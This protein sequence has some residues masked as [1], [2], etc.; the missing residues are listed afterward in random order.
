LGIRAT[1][2]VSG[3]LLVTCV[4]A[5]A[6]TPQQ[7]A[8]QRIDLA[9]SLAAGMLRAVNRDVT[10][11]QGSQ[12]G[13]HMSD[14]SDPGIVW[15]Q[16]SD[17]TQGTI[18]VDVRGRDQFQRS[19]IGIAFHG[20]DDRTYEAVY[21]RPFN[22]RTEDV[23]S[24]RHA[25]QYMALPEFDWPRLRQKFPEEFEGP[26]DSS[27]VPSDWVTLRVLVQGQIVEVYVGPSK[28]P[29]LRIRKLGE[30]NRGIIGLWT[31]NNSDGDFAN[32]RITPAK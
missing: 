28:T 27:I 26:V 11:L 4:L 24:H 32:L 23:T 8:Q 14:R 16:G 21:L 22:F 30:L 20:V 5:V 6:Q 2:L 1:T 31:G 13:V 7:G 29:A 9:S 12:N 10:K 3:V 15:I 25:I 19:F 17:F 18:E